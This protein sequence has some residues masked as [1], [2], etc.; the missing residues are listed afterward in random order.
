MATA[1]DPGVHTDSETDLRRA[2]AELVTNASRFTRL[3]S[4]IS[5][6]TK[7][8][9]WMRALSLLEEYGP[10]RVSELARLDSSSQPTA[11]ALLKQLGAAGLVRRQRDPED[12]RAV[13]VEMTEDGQAW[14]AAARDHVGAALAAH[15]HGRDADRVQR[16]SR[17]L[18]DLRAAVKNSQHSQ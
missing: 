14:L 16:I 1:D 17:G 7:P 18:H 12:S 5:T 10:L 8:R 15:L 3:A 9:P 6:D 4:S 2:L 11:T 13:V